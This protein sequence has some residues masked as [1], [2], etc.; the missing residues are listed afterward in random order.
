MPL[1]R[2][3]FSPKRSWF[4]TGLSLCAQQVQTNRTCM[5]TGPK[6]CT[7]A[8][9]FNRVFIMDS[10]KAV[11]LCIM[12]I[13][14]KCAYIY[15]NNLF[16]W[17]QLSSSSNG[18]KSFVWHSCYS[19]RLFILNIHLSW[20]KINISY[21]INLAYKLSLF[22]EIK[23]LPLAAFILGVQSTLYLALMLPKG[24]ENCGEHIAYETSRKSRN[25]LK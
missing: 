12:Y 17:K 25:L 23:I 4:K 13:S 2:P 11:T 21:N 5:E 3:F 20:K 7:C 9:G 6:A 15:T 16:A 18:C 19:D 8:H 22:S 14:K 10:S 24:D 1:K